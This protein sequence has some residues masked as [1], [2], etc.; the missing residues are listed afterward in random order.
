MSGIKTKG[1][2][3]LVVM[4]GDGEVPRVEGVRFETLS[5]PFTFEELDM[6]M[7]R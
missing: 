3:R 5:K 4:T 2:K 1:R 7:L 6:V